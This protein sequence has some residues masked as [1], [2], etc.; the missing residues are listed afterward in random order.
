MGQATRCS[1]RSARARAPA[2]AP[3][4]PWGD[5]AATNSSR[6]SRRRR[7]RARRAWRRSYAPRFGSRT[8]SRRRRQPTWARAWASR[9]S[10]STGRTPR[11]CSAPPTVRSITR[12]AKEKTGSR[13]RARRA[14]RARKP[15]R[16]LAQPGDVLGERLRVVLGELRRDRR[17]HL[18]RASAGRIGLEPTFHEIRALSRQARVLRGNSMARCAVTAGARRR[19]D[20]LD[21][22]PP[23]LLA[24]LGERLVTRHRFH[25]LLGRVVLADAL[26]VLGRESRGHALHDRARARARL[27]CG[28]LRG[29]VIGVLAREVRVRG[30]GTASVGAVACGAYGRPELLAALEVRLGRRIGRAERACVD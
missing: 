15:P 12:S 4:T 30:C 20:A 14:S 6:S 29:D 10:R 7:S 22:G 1:G 18:M 17:H 23:E 26:H 16:D 2:C 9:C 13:W 3:R 5:W 8:K 21:A 25:G 28:E 11:I 27:E 19:V 24:A